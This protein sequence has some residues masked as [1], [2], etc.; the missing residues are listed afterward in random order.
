MMTMMLIMMVMLSILTL[1]ILLLAGAGRLRRAKAVDGHGKGMAE[2]GSR[3][4]QAMPIG[5]LRSGGGARLR[6]EGAE[7]RIVHEKNQN[8]QHHH[9]GR[10]THQHQHQRPVFDP[11]KAARS[12][13]AV[14]ASTSHKT[15]YLFNEY[16]NPA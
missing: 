14:V 6:P 2:G 1:H 13:L 4:P 16:P 15:S 8:R 10:Q 9:H 11:P 3:V 5:S 12:G 7:Q